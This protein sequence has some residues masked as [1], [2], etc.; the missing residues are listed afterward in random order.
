MNKKLL[1]SCLLTSMPSLG[2]AAGDAI[3]AEI[4]SA[5]DRVKILKMMEADKIYEL[6]T[7]ESSLRGKNDDFLRRRSPQD[8]LNSGLSSGCGDFAAA[9]YYLM[10]NKGIKVLYLDAVELSAHSL[11][12]RFNGHTGVAVLDSKSGHWVLVDP[13]NHEIVSENWDI[14]SKI[15]EDRYWIWYLGTLEDYPAKDPNE[16]KAFYD[17]ALKSIPPEIWEERLV[18]LDFSL[19]SSMRR[20]GSLANP[21]SQEFLDKYSTL[22]ERLDISPRRRINVILADSGLEDEGGNCLPYMRGLFCA[23]GRKSAMS[24]GWF[25]WIEKFALR[26]LPNSGP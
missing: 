4:R 24:Q 23:N 17:K 22:Y 15:Y 6:P 14:R 21:H 16:L 12:N 1:L 2:Y 11:M 10:R 9:F 13:T 8:I 25:A 3:L 7:R 19:D 18:R 26:T 5:M 20:N